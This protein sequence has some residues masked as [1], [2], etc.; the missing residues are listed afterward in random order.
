MDPTLSLAFAMHSNRGV[1]ALLLGSG[2]SRSAAIPTG[3]EVVVDLIR[4]LA[5]MQGASCD[6]NPETWFLDTYGEEATYSGLLKKLCRTP[7]ERQQLLRRY[8]EASPEE[9]ASGQKQPRK[10]HQAIAALAKT[11][12]IRVILTTNFDRLMERSLEAVGVSPT[13]IST[14]NAVDGATPLTHAP[15]T[16]VKLHGDY[17]DARIKNTPDELA[18]YDRRVDRL[19]DRVFDEFGLVV[20][21]WSAD[22]DEA[23]GRAVLRGKGRR[24]T[25]YW[26]VRG[27]ASD[28]AQRLIAHRA[29]E[30]IP[31][32]GA[33]EF[34]SGLH[35]KVLSLAS[36]DPPHPLSAKTAVATMKR[37]LADNRHR[38]ELHDLVTGEVERVMTVTSD[39]EMPLSVSRDI[40]EARDR[41]LRYD[42][43]TGIVRDL[44]ITGAQWG[45]PEHSRLWS[46]SLERLANRSDDVGGSTLLI[47]MRRYPA[48]LALYAAGVAAVAGDKWL[49]LRTLLRDSRIRSRRGDSVGQP[50]ATEL[51]PQAI[52]DSDKGSRVLTPGQQSHT[53]L[54]NHI[55]KALREPLRTQVPSDDD[56]SEFFDQFEYLSALVYV[57]IHQTPDQPRTWFPMG[58]FAWRDRWN[59]LPGM[60]NRVENHSNSWATTG[61]E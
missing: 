8:F 54:S 58:R 59:G 61:L 13:V 12:H 16:V 40:E 7:A 28:S 15:C 25:T 14:P 10:A 17:L 34:F 45:G 6:P 18:K 21:G 37:Y 57:D 26:A 51:Y 44:F 36:F 43:I 29:A 2:I 53:P 4:K 42:S 55:F 47:A 35:E 31:I 23:L 20:A 24:F 11:G 60:I 56:Y 1:Y 32:V 52:L 33:D 48:L 30:T 27:T 19:L 38:I 49:M 50:A 9:A 46:S 41:L 22:W 3:W 39:A 5:A